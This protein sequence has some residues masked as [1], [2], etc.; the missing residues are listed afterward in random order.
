MPT[1]WRQHNIEFPDRDTA[2]HVAAHDLRPVLEQAQVDGRLHQWWFVRKQPFKVRYLAD[3][4]T[5][6]PLSDLLNALTEQGQ[7]GWWAGGIYE[8]ETIAFGG[9][10]GMDLAHRL[11]HDDSRHLLQR[12]PGRNTPTTLGNR[13]TMVLLCSAMLPA[14]GLDWCEQ[15]DV[16]AQFAAFRPAEPGVEPRHDARLTAAMHRLMTVDARSLCRRE[17]PGALAGFDGW[18]TAFE[19]TGQ[20]LAD[21]ARHGRLQ[22]GLRGVLA[23]HMIFHANRARLLGHDQ[24]LLGALAL[25]TVFP[26]IATT[27]QP[28]TECPSNG[29]N[30]VTTNEQP[31]VSADQLRQDLT[32]RLTKMK[33]V[34][35]LPVEAAFRSTPRHLFLPG[36][37]VDQAYADNP[38]YTKHDGAGTSISAASQ[39]W[40][41]AAMLEQLDAQPGHRILEAGAGTGYNAALMGAIVGDTGHVATIDVDE[42]LVDG[43]RKNLA[44]AG[45][46][47]VEVL[48]ADGALGHEPGAPYDR[49]IATVGAYEVPTAWLDQL[50]EGG[51]LVVPLRLRGTNS[52]S[53][54]FERRDDRWVS[55]DSKLAVFM[56]L[57]GIGDDARRIVSLTDTNDITLQTHKDQNVDDRALTD[58]LATERTETWTGVTFPANVPYEW[59]ELWLCLHL[60]NALMRMNVTPAAADRGLVTPMFPWGSMASTRG[61]DLIYLTT[62]PAEPAADGSKLYEV[63]VIAHGP[64]SDT[65]AQQ[66][67]ELIQTWDQQYRS[68][69]VRFE[70]PDTAESSDP[71]AGRFV[72]D[73]P[74]HP[75]TVIWE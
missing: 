52:R 42:D 16:W 56:P 34:R 73:R 66:A 50:A 54:V 28:A 13:E 22:R 62:R 6:D 4:A 55:I 58:V 70:M 40:M 19:R 36:V 75:I 63:G 5:P 35:S 49:I 48:L 37:P 20:A 17:P 57:R 39:P 53:V 68:R 12:A 61:G 74:H 23:H 21:L 7:I 60:D 1:V 2:D 46:G 72:L 14:A 41:V 65:L 3:P 38:V 8:P 44:A 27:G 15:G 32:D 26:D 25:S 29:A 69:S 59:M 43:A 67:A 33:V 11:F 31:G 24:H 30:Y 51:R 47:N 9:E 64:T 10:A 71:A 18:V 45:I